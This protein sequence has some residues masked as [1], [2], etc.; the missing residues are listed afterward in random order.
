[1]EA[2]QGKFSP[3]ETVGVQQA[4][5]H[6]FSFF[7]QRKSC[8]ENPPDEITRDFAVIVPYYNKRLLGSITSRHWNYIAGHACPQDLHQEAWTTFWIYG[9]GIKQ[10][11]VAGVFS[12]LRKVIVNRV[13][14]EWRKHAW[15]ERLEENLHACGNRLWYFFDIFDIL[16]DGATDEKQYRFELLCKFFEET[17]PALSARQRELIRLCQENRTAAQITAIMGFPTRNAMSNRK[18]RAYQKLALHMCRCLQRELQNP[19][20][21]LLDREII[22]EWL[23]RME[24]RLE[25]FAKRGVRKKCSIATR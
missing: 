23:E 4:L 20:A 6:V 14:D 24:T 8:Q 15:Q 7:D 2:R 22:A 9:S 5:D 19:H 21:R 10:R 18:R 13:A 11:T 12:W 1:M 17:L 16:G 3:E 25:R